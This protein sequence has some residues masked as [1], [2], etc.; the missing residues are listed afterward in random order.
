MKVIGAGL[1][2][3][4][5]LTQKVALEMLGFG[6]CYHM[7][8]V[9]GNLDAASRWR[10]A[11][12]GRDG[13]DD[14]FGNFQATV[15]WPG[16]FF[17]REL[18]EAYPDAKVLLSV[19]DGKAWEQSMG[20]TIWGI[21]YG[22]M[23][24]HDL[25]TAWARVDPKWAT[26]ISL[27]KEMWQ[28]SGLLASEA[29]GAA[30]GAMASAMERYNDEVKRSVPADRLLVWAPGDGWAPLCEFLGVGVPAAPLP[31]VNDAKQFGDRIVDAA[32]AALSQWREHEMPVGVRG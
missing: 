6:P 31:H 28:K 32:L 21:F 24:I 30:T 8:N 2:R 15:D 22:D 27:M 18:M 29:E 12:E 19:R 11:L 10:E 4:A 17:Y 3:T 26:Y 14:I 23:L 7:V 1:P 5:T 16:A 9:L 13:W 25:S 20:E